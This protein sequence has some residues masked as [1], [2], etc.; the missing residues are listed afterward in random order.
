[1]RARDE[2]VWEGLEGLRATATFPAMKKALAILL[3]SAL[4]ACDTFAEHR[5]RNFDAAMAIP[6]AVENPPV[7]RGTAAPTSGPWLVPYA[8]IDAS[9][10][11]RQNESGY[12]AK[13]RN[14]ALRRDLRPDALLYFFGGEAVTGAVATYVGF[15]ISTVNNVVRP[16]AT[17]I[18]C[19]ACPISTGIRARRD[20]MVTS[21]DESA[22]A[23]GILEGDTVL[24]IDGCSVEHPADDVS[25]WAHRV[26]AKRPGDKLRVVW[27]RPGTGR[28]EGEI[29]AQPPAP[30]TF[31]GDLAA[32][33]E[34]EMWAPIQGH[35][36]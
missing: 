33:Q 29:V 9:F 8:K 23:C 15:G 12:A 6:A 31:E 7:F 2:T 13:L 27:I 32:R 24:T 21:L 3:L 1:M 20:Y 28:M 10:A 22:K 19:R 4:A 5:C 34:T 25:E 26:L 36:P 18:C 35:R 30:M 11:D 17:A 16:Q 14:E